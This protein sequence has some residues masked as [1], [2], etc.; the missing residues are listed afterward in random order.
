MFCYWP[1]C[2]L[3]A[4]NLI[5]L[6]QTLCFGLTAAD[7]LSLPPRVCELKSGRCPHSRSSPPVSGRGSLWPRKISVQFR[8]LLRQAELQRIRE[9]SSYF[10]VAISNIYLRWLS[11]AFIFILCADINRFI[12]SKIPNG[13][14]FKE[15]ARR[16]GKHTPMTNI[17]SDDTRIHDLPAQN[18]IC[19]I[20]NQGVHWNSSV[21]LRFRV[22][23]YFHPNAQLYRI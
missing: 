6:M 19:K 21:R 7:A 18:W 15:K 22:L 23:P 8:S 3:H 4:F 9:N 16:K 10:I 11:S 17:H 13:V 12:R 2:P 14:P 5:L 20:C 1:S